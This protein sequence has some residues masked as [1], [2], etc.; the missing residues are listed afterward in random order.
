VEHPALVTLDH[1]ELLDGHL[2]GTPATEVFGY[3]PGWGLPS[4]GDLAVLRDI[5]RRG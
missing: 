4:A 1:L 2:A 5:V 3:R